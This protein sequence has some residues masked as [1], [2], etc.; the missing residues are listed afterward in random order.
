M[1]N[2]LCACQ[3]KYPPFYFFVKEPQ[4]LRRITIEILAIFFELVI[5]ETM[6]SIRCVERSVVQFENSF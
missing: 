1:Q 2:L 4:N 5:H 3:K 6:M